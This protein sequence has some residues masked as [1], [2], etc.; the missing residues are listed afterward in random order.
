MEIKGDFKPL[1]EIM[2]SDL[3]N[4]IFELAGPPMEFFFYLVTGSERALLIDGGFGIGSAMEK[5]REITDL[6]VIHICTHGHPDH[7]GAS[8]E[9]DTFLLCPA[10]NDVYE[11][12]GT[13]A[14]RS[15]DVSHMP[16]GEAFLKDMQPDGPAPTPVSDGEKIDLGGRVLEVIYAPGHT[17]GSICIFD[18]AT[19]SMF[20]GDNVQGFETAIREWNA[21]SLEEYV[22][23]L[24]K[25]KSHA[26]RILYGGH[27]P[28][29]NDPS[30]INKYILCAQDII[31]GAEGEEK[32]GRGGM[33]SLVYAKD[34]VQISY[35]REK[36]HK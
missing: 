20:T 34:G 33:M 28:N 18:E 4:G 9:F 5:V 24:K 2:W 11:Q 12:M 17:H 10:D 1:T 36:I 8:A 26:P 30:L 19:S 35:V 31:D 22:E 13:L 14:F 25:L 3:G 27:R 16:G 7:V 15:G 23:S 29:R 32:P 21:S 6:P